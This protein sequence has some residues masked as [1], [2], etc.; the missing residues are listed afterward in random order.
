M[1]DTEVDDQLWD[2]FHQLVNM[3]SRQ[4]SEWLR[5]TGGYTETE[6]LPDHAGP[7]LGRRILAILGKRR[8]D[9]DT[10]DIAVMRTAVDRITAAIGPDAEDEPRAGSDRWRRRLMSMGHD[11]L[12]PE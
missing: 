8:T 3:S 10:D 12:G 2:E 6:T 5:T 9:V 7:E 4:L 11:P 1:A